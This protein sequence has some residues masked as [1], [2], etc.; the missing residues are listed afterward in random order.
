MI[1]RFDKFRILSL[2]MLVVMAVMS[3][4]KPDG[5]S[6]QQKP[7]P[8]PIPTPTPTPSIVIDS[9]VDTKPILSEDGGDFKISFESTVS[10]TA[11]V[12]ESK[13]DLSWVTLDR[14]SGPAGHVSIGV[15]VSANESYSARSAIVRIVAGSKVQ[16]ITI[17]QR[18][19]EDRTVKVTG[20]SLKVDG[21]A[22]ITEGETVTIIATVLPENA[23]NKNV[24]WTSSNSDVA[25]VTDGVVTGLKPGNTRITVKTEDGGLTSSCQIT[26]QSS[27][28]RV[29]SVSLNST[30]ATMD[31]G[32]TMTLTAKV[33]PEDATNKR[34]SWE[35]GN[36]SVA[37]VGNNGLVTAVG[38]GST[39]ITVTTDDGGY[40]ATCAITV[41]EPIIH[42]QSVSLRSETTTL[43]VG[44]TMGIDAIVLP[45][46]ASNKK[47]SWSSDNKSVAQ[48]NDK[49]VV[50][51]IEAGS[52]MITATTEDGGL[53]A[54]ISVTVENPVVPVSGIYLNTPQ[55]NIVVDGT[56]SLIATVV[57]EN[58]TNK[59]VKWKSD[60]S[61]VAKVDN[62]VVS[63]MAV[64]TA[65]ISAETEDGGYIA[66]CQV[67]VTQKEIP[68]ESISIDYDGPTNIYVGQSV[69]LSVR[70]LPENA[71]NKNITWESSNDSVATVQD[72][73][74]TGFGAGTVTIT[75]TAVDGGS[76][77]SCQISVEE[78]PVD[79]QGV[80]LEYE[81]NSMFIGETLTMRAVIF[82]E[83]A[84]DKNVTWYSDN[85]SVA[86]VDNGYIAGISEGSA[87]ITVIT[88]QGGYSASCIVYVNDPVI[89]VQTVAL[90]FDTDRVNIGETLM[91]RAVIYPEDAANKAV[92]WQSNDENVATVSDGIVT[93]ISEGSAYITATAQD[94]G[95]TAGCWISVDDPIIH[96]SYVSIEYIERSVIGI[97][98]TSVLT[99]HVY[100]ED[101]TNK[102]VIWT[103]SNENV[104]TV[105]DGVV[106]GVSVGTA[107][108][109]A[110]AEDGGSSTTCTIS[111]EIPVESIVL[112]TI[113]ATLNVG[114]TLTI[115][116]TVL[117]E[118]ATNRE[119]T[120]NSGNTEIATV[121]DG[122]VT[123]L[124]QGDVWIMASCAGVSNNCNVRVVNPNLVS[125][126][127]WQFKQFCLERFD[128]DND[129]EISLDEAAAVKEIDYTTPNWVNLSDIKYF[130]NLESLK[131]ISTVTDGYYTLEGHGAISEL[132]KLKH[133]E[134]V[135]FGLYNGSFNISG[136]ADLEYL[137]IHD[138][139]LNFLDVSKNKK[140]KY[141]DCSPM[142]YDSLEA[143]AIY[144]GQNIPNVTVDRNPDYI[145]PYTKIYV[146]GSVVAGGNE[147]TREGD[148]I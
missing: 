81:T 23:T 121:E 94:G 6:T 10:W 93:G 22:E 79:V 33:L 65:N 103:S 64:G 8:T 11:S 59:S 104:A 7:D 2:A 61:S 45:E 67:T 132:N 58:A 46:N 74:V 139:Y 18:A 105:A 82:P 120:W 53:S 80:S 146:E 21:S 135:H 12:V 5:G 16:D 40:T 141:L 1:V 70:I 144:K 3:C 75:V 57:P 28:V 76:T 52:A 42:V 130:V 73:T 143:I 9:G 24:S 128:L 37:T 13:A 102:N 108:I 118:N 54:S 123:A 71:T 26:V 32:G 44:E 41:N 96:V 60:N 78:A 148:E 115:K 56:L 134:I 92:E 110:T 4:N 35:T 63:A 29:Q 117:P 17:T 133:L 36:S 119:I 100:P 25:S 68:V 106:T 122:V 113:S 38:A 47:L 86:T 34:V 55:E 99:V 140:L 39:N 142:M 97:G 147:G 43:L 15:T 138:S 98:E 101:A 48:V 19:K 51:G 31:V 131:V 84:T 136:L 62:G 145:P 66:S 49:G 85:E 69:T 14:T 116:A 89:H 20:V 114:E 126:N 109:T 95:A 83:N 77:D 30:S 91:L 87:V 27:T 111:V 72:G 88:E 125:F 112:D 129:G 50:S 107:D 124:K 127:D 137:D 90:E